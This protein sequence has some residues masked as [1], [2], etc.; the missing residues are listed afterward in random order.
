MSG[1]CI[2]FGL[3]AFPDFANTKAD[4]PNNSILPAKNFTETIPGSAI[5]IE[6]VEK[7]PDIKF[8]MVYLPG[9]EFYMGSNNGDESPIHKVVIKP[10]WIGKCEVS[11]DEFDYWWKN[12][13]LAMYPK[14]PPF[15]K[16]ADA[17]TRP[18]NPYVPEDYDFTKEGRPAICMSHHAAMMYCHW[19][20]TVTKKYYRLPTEAEWEYACRAGSKSA[21]CYGDDPKQLDD[22]AWYADNSRDEDLG[23]AKATHKVGTKKPNAWGIHD[24]HGNVWEWCIDLYEPNFYATCVQS[25][26]EINPVNLPKSKKWGHVVRGGSFKDDPLKLRSSARWKSEIKWMYEDPQD[27]RSIWWLTRYSQIGFR[28]C[29]PVEEYPELVGLKPSVIKLSEHDEPREG[30]KDD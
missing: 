29:L 19:L 12:E 15:P 20:R 8:E 1:V 14:D 25:K 7:C 28:I 24:M 5:R 13:Q 11:W 23:K 22:Y 4:S 3:L 30:R 17:I 2:A 18:T 9:G 27:P 21:Y 10:F 6:G 26:L 16:V